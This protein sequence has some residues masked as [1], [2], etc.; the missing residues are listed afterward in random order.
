MILKRVRIAY[1]HLFQPY[2]Y[3]DGPNK[4]YEATFLIEKSDEETIA[5]IRRACSAAKEKKFAGKSVELSNPMRDGDEMNQEAFS[6][7]WVIRAK[8]KP[9]EDGSGRPGVVLPNLKQAEPDDIQ[10]GDFVNADIAA[11]GYDV[12]GNKGIAFA[13][14][15]VQLVAKG[16]RIGGGKARAENVFEALEGVAVG[17]DEGGKDESEKWF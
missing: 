2:A 11:F 8:S 6:G 13:L 5:Q 15:N 10:S 9:R 17:D 12:S 16:D 3:Q 7:H 1:P 14:N 4:K